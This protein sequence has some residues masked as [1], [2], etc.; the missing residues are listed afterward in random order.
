MQVDQVIFKVENGVSTVASQQVA[1][2]KFPGR[3]LKDAKFVDDDH[4][5][6]ALIEKC[7]FWYHSFS[8][9]MN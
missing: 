7:E 4:V 9:E 5:M 2:T 3:T 8:A 6:V 1:K